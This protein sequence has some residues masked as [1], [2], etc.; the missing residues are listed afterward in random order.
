MAT[1]E[2]TMEN[3]EEVVTGNDVVIVDFW[4]SWC[5]PCRAFAPTYEAASELHPDVVFAKVNTE[6]QQELAGAFNIRSIPTLMVFREKVILYSEAG[7]L[8][9]PAQAP[10]PVAP[11]SPP[12]GKCPAAGWR[13]CNLMADS[14]LLDWLPD[15]M[16][17]TGRI[18]GQRSSGFPHGA[19]W[20]M[21]PCQPG[22]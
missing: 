16:P 7:A 13:S 19:S 14:G 22:W 2:L 5:G 3:F 18:T 4:A 8:P 6:E 15:R 20:L 11:P 12:S 17:S 1:I 10:A 21:G 9:A